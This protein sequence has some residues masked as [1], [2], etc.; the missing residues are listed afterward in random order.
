MK[1]YLLIVDVSKCSQCYNCV[2]ACK[3]EHFGNE[4]LPVSTGPQELG[5][6]WLELRVQE[7]GS[8]EKDPRFLL[9]GRLPPL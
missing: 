5:Q 6:D 1:R 4:F 9:A 8:G 7:R 2:L 3:D